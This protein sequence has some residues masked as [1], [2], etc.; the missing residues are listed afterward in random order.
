MYGYGG[1]CSIGM[2]DCG[3]GSCCSGMCGCGSCSCD[4]SVCGCSDGS[5]GGGM[6]CC[7]GDRICGSGSC[8]GNDGIGRQLVCKLTGF[9]V[10]VV[11]L[12][13]RLFV[14]CFGR[15]QFDF[16]SVD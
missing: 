9:V 15:L 5:C 1:G 12:F 8:V 14:C 11:F 7:G 2:F 13:V 16:Y 10:V 4:G 3:G 6:C